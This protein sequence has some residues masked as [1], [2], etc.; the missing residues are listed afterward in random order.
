MF[1]LAIHFDLSVRALRGRVRS[2]LTCECD[3]NDGF[4]REPGATHILPNE[5]VVFSFQV[6]QLTPCYGRLMKHGWGTNVG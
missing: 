6:Y 4:Y 1:G 2:G 3:E 5:N